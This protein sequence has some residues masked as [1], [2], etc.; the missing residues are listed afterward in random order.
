M[1]LLRPPALALA[2][3]ALSCAS[4][5]RFSPQLPHDVPDVSRWEQKSGRAP[6]VN[7]SGVIDYALF[8]APSRPTVYSVTRYRVTLQSPHA[9]QNEKLQ[10]DK[11]GK[12]VRRYECVPHAAD[13]HAPCDWREFARGSA[14]YNAELGALITVYFGSAPGLI[15]R[16]PPE[17][18]RHE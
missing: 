9:T 15:D 11:D 3:T 16:T 13:P 18:G 17:P 2:A 4:S 6:C 7:P 1:Q 5:A 12:D 14:E 10:W 8:V